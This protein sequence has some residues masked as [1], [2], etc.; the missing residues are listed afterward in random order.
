MGEVVGFKG[1]WVGEVVGPQ[2]WVGGGGGWP[3]RVGGRGRWLA[4]KGGW[5]GEVVAPPKKLISFQQPCDSSAK[6]K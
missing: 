2:G 3:P 1:G 5:V 6:K 4:P